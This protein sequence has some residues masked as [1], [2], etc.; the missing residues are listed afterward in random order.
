MI[1]VLGGTSDSLKIAEGLQQQEL[2]FYLSVV[3]DYG[4]K[5]AFEV[6]QQV[7]QGRMDIAQ[8]SAFIEEKQIQLVI[9]AT[10]PF[11]VEVSKNAIAACQQTDCDYL[12]FER[13]SVMPEDVITVETIE[14]ACQAATQYDG[15]I[16][17]TTG[18]KTLPQFIQYLP[19]EQL[20]VR[21][22]PTAEVL[23]ICEAC[24]LQ[25]DQIE[26]I[27]GPFS[28]EM[29]QVLLTHNQAAVMITKESGQAGGFMEKVTACQKLGIPCIVM[30]REKLEYPQIAATAAEVIQRAK[31]KELKI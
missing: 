11:A 26:A 24:G 17:L 21:V 7:I 22:L 29:N 16:Y 12:R 2:E 5:L 15:K 30:T 19:K 4:A 28:E 27:K 1:L 14:A 13:P 9:D 23:H 20:I 8:L 25:A 3:S 18:S 10:H 6:T 31:E